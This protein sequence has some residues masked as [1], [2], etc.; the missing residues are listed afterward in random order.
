MANCPVAISNTWNSEIAAVTQYDIDNSPYGWS[1]FPM[2][3]TTDPNMAPSAG[4][5]INLTFEVDPTVTYQYIRVI[6]GELPP[7]DLQLSLAMRGARWAS[8]ADYQS[9]H[10]TVG[11]RITNTGTNE[12]YNV[13]L[14]GATATNGVTLST[15]CSYENQGDCYPR[16]LMDTLSGGATVDFSSR[17]VVPPGTANFRTTVTMEAVDYNNQLHY[18]PPGS[19]PP[20]P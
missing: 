3:F 19:P 13:M 10:L 11:Y 15:E 12:A 4:H 7:L 1:D 5:H 6:I 2:M 20:T 9:R 18:F 16:Y 17:F 8:Y 14:T